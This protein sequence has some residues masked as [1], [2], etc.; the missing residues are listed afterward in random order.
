MDERGRSR[1]NRR[2]VKVADAQQLI[3][4]AIRPVGVEQVALWQ[5]CGRR[6]A[7]TL[8]AT[9]DWPPFARSGLDGFAIRGAD[10]AHASPE[11]PVTLQVIDAVAAGQVARQRVEPGTAVRI[12]TG[13]AM[14]EGADAV[15][16]LEQT[17][18][19]GLAGQTAVRVKHAARP[20]QNVA[21][22]GEEFRCGSAIAGPG[23]VIRPGHIGLLGTFGYAELPV[24]A[25][26]RVAVFA[27]GSELLPVAAPLEPGRI[28]DSNSAMVAAMVAQSGGEPVLFGRLPDRVDAVIEALTA[29]LAEADCI[30]T[31]GGV[32]VGDYDVM[33]ILLSE[34]KRNHALKSELMKPKS[35][36]TLGQTLEPSSD[37]VCF[38]KVLFDRVAMRPGSPTSAA[39]LNGK[40]LFA[41]S[42]NPGACYVGFELFVRPALHRMQGELDPLPRPLEAE[43]TDQIRK[44]SP[45]ERYVRCK[46][47]LND[48]R[49]F[50]EPL[51]FGKSSMMASIPQADGLLVVPSGPEGAAAGSRVKVLPV[52]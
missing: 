49:V 1:F 38:S 6:L 15:V 23:T 7:Q 40:P 16:M 51:A 34:M 52:P 39:L 12:M 18:P 25:R 5:G 32:S 47:I 14:P 2:A 19:A 22:P 13:A 46:L 9:S 50:A 48:G 44:G 35:Q 10:A 31:I 43:L 8:Q 3:L 20:G 28:R 30:I 17:A 45:H 11:H 37:P 26:P 41:L 21:L 33:A 36:E 4:E 24:Y 27:T 42:G 29:A